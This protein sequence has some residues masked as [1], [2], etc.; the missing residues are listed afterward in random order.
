MLNN[1]NTE[2][3]KSI[4]GLKERRENIIMEIKKEEERKLELESFIEK[5]KRDFITLDGNIL[6]NNND[7]DN[8]D[9]NYE[10]KGEFDRVINNTEN[11]F[12]KVF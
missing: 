8:L 11:A 1:Y 9:K 3:V 4:E 5:L 7:L 10:I 12:N 6:L 2:L